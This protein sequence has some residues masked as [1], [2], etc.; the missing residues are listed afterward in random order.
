[1][2]GFTKSKL[3]RSRKKAT[4]NYLLFLVSISLVVYI[5]RI[6]ELFP[7]LGKLRITLLLFAGSLLLF[8]GSNDVK[9]FPLQENRELKL[10]LLFLLTSF[11]SV[12]FSVW[13]S[14][15]LSVCTSTLLINTLV[16]L[17]AQ[18]AIHNEKDFFQIINVIIISSL[19]LLFGIFFQPHIVEDYRVTTTNSYDPNDIA[20]FFVFCFPIVLSRFIPAKFLGK[21][22]LATTLLLLALATIQTGS[23]GGMLAFG[24]AIAGIFFSRPLQL[25]SSYKLLTLFMITTLLFSSNGDVL[26]ERFNRVISGEDY[27]IVTT[28]SAASGRLAIWKSGFAIFIRNPI[29]GVGAGTS[30]TAMGE[31]FGNTSWK[32]MHNSF[33]QVAVEMGIPGLLLYIAML[34]RIWSNC[35]RYLREQISTE[36]NSMLS[37]AAAIKI[38]LIVYIVAAVFLSQAFSVI[39]PLSL[40]LSSKLSLNPAK[41][42]AEENNQNKTGQL[43]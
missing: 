43:L 31:K 37:I 20:M 5:A 28:D 19:F 14:H 34:H 12:P 25:K 26:Q 32:T 4:T 24:I 18:T 16:F 21:T 36:D 40:A 29:L 2:D 35:Q 13:P 30:S 22:F 17:F 27:N 7:V 10:I 15:S 39:V 33:L 1:M 11:I 38:S 8:L 3:E 6:P 23:R 41:T 42:S 9:K